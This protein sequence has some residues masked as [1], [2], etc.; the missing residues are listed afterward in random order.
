M[1][2]ILSSY[3]NSIESQYYAM[4]IG[5]SGLADKNAGFSVNFKFLGN[6]I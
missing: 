1:V 2:K 3:R 4:E 6:N 5:L